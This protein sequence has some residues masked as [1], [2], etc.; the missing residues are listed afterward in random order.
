[1]LNLQ[2]KKKWIMMKIKKL[3][4]LKENLIDLEFR[5]KKKNN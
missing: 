4:E 2:T 5:N 1:M 3:I